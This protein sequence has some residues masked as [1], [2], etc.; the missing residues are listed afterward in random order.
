MNHVLGC[1]RDWAR[2]TYG[3]PRHDDCATDVVL[4]DDDF[5]SIVNGI[6]E[7]RVLF[8]NLTKTI[9]YTLTHLIPELVAVL[10]NIVFSIPAGM[11]SLMILRSV[12][13][14]AACLS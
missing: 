13:R 1:S 11:S 7:G 6:E 8:D 12:G 4:M 3:Y 9:A 5:C 10:I 14:S 2:R